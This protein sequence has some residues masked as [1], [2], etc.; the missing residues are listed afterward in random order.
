LRVVLAELGQL[1]GWAVYD[2]GYHGLAQCVYIAALRAAHSADD[3]PMGAHILASMANQAA[4]HGR[5]A[6]AVTLIETAI[7]GTRG[8]QTPALLAQLHMRHA[9]AFASLRDTSACTAAISK[10]CI[11][12]DQLKPDDD[13]PW[14]YW[15][16]PAAIMVNTGDCLRELGQFAHA[17]AMLTEGIGQFSESFVRDRQI[18]VTHLADALARPGKQR[19]FDAA[20]GLG[21]ESIDLAESLDSTNGLGYLRDLYHQLKPHTKL[22]AVRD[23]LERAQ[24][25]VAV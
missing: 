2:A 20:A 5:P 14:L 12:V 23:F 22:P 13:P 19:D 21:M 15:V 18:Y 3:R 6:D 4:R 8:R 17:A 1:C 16:S 7:A 24:G 10:A 25:F 9:Y 11:Q